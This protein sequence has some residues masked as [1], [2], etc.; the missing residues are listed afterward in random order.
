MIRDLGQEGFLEAHAPYY[1]DLETDS[2]LPL[3]L[4]CT[5]FTRL[6][7][8]L[9]LVNLKARFGWS[10]KSLTELL[11]L[12]KNMLPND[13]KLPNSHYEAKKILCPVGLEYKKIH[14]CR[15][16]CVLY[17]KEFAKLRN[18]PTCGVS[19]YK[20]NDGE[21]ID[22]VATSNPRP[23]KVCWHL[24]IIPRF[25]RLFAIAH[26]ASNLKWHAADRIN[27]GFLRHS[28][29][30]PQW[31]TIDHL[32]PEFGAEPRNLRLGLASDGMNPFGNLSTNHSSWL[33]LLMIY[34]LPPSLCMKRKYIMLSM[35][36]S[37][38]RQPGNDIDV[39]FTPLIEDMRKLWVDGVDVYDANQGETFR[40]HAMI[41]CTI[42][43]FPAYGNL[44]GYSVKGHQACPICEQNTSFIQLKHG[45]KTVYTRHRRFLKHYHPYRRLK[46]AFNG[47]QETEEPS[48]SLAPHEVYDRVKDIVT[49]FVA[50][51][52]I[53][54]EKVRVAISRLCFFFNAICRKV[55]DPKQLDDLE[56]EAAMILC[57]LEMYFPPSFF[58][59][60]VH[61]IV[62]LVREIRLC[63]PVFL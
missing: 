32:Y 38:P 48:E 5:T 10:D 47:S 16:D 44:S 25:K 7:A 46:K 3:Y 43:D 54:P 19:R 24:P 18:C 28:A 59:I 23:A 55:I 22:D 14:A 34:N 56:N 50:V 63:G 15:N 35:M 49:V 29:D 6:S 11:V 17:R 45:K 20:Q 13:N 51:R 58:D 36:I 40:L 2:K 57:Q 33:V 12:L 1:E 42:N 27:D 9:A 60:M 31:K 62:H 61:L 52:G 39:Y 41:F 26:D 30:S 21:Y 4:G 53:L 8:V 37:G